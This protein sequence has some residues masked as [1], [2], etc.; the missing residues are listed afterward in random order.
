MVELY[1]EIGHIITELIEKYNLVAS[2]NKIIKLFSER[3]TKQFGKGFN[4]SNL[5]AIK[6]FI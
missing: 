6:S 2:Q 4:I 1:Y 3:L 5:K